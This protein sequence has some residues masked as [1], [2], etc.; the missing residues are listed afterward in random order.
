MTKSRPFGHFDQ[1]SRQALDTT[2]LPIIVIGAG[3]AGL[4]SALVLAREYP[5]IPITIVA[6]HM[7]G[8]YDPEYASPVAG[9]DFMPM[10]SKENS[11]WERETWPELKRLA[12]HFPEAGIH[13]Q[14][15][16][17]RGQFDDDPWF[18]PILDDYKEL[19]TKDLPVGVASGYEF[20]SVCINTALYLAWLVGQCR[21]AGV[22]LRRGIIEHISDARDLGHNGNSAGIVINCTGLGASRLRGV[23]DNQMTPIR[24]QVVLIRNEIDIMY[25][26]SGTDDGPD[27]ISYCMARASGGGTVVGGTYQIHNWDTTPDPNTSVRMLRRITELVPS[28]GHAKGVADLDIIRHAVG[29][30]PHR[31]TGVRIERECLDDGLH[32]VHNYGHSGWGFQ[33]SYGCANRVLEL[34]KG[35]IATV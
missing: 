5:A 10:A 17:G 12:Q 32:V 7:P 9:A 6:K 14:S 16:P 26:I 13:F 22:V 34:V 33:G 8:D 31:M 15:Q 19:E 23:E 11:R 30:R 18:R 20:R 2:T 21:R 4:T 27:E 28:L 25:T 35:I 3:V 29:L 24:G 1:A